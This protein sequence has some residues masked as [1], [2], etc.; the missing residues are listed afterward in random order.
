[1]SELAQ[2]ADIRVLESTGDLV[3]AAV[4]ILTRVTRQALV[5]RE[6]AHIGLAGGSTP[7]YVYRHWAGHGLPWQ[8]VHFWLGDERC[9][10][11]DHADANVRMAR[12]TL[13]AALAHGAVLHGVD[14]VEADAHA[15]AEAYGRQLPVLDL[16][17][18]G[19]GE[20]GHTASLFP[21]HP[22][23]HEQHERVIAI[24]GAPK[25]P[26]RRVTITRRVIAEAHELLVLVTGE[27]KAAALAATIAG[28]SAED[29]PIRLAG[30]PRAIWLVDRAAWSRISP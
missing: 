24:D 17:V 26:P 29:L 10:P 12:D 16:L 5:E 20:D 22:G 8:G 27:Q 14:G 25:P 21:H 9:V 19:M 6:V 15:A 23:L 28:G 30:R 7:E 13:A 2:L 3:T 18:L 4:G 1:M 11:P